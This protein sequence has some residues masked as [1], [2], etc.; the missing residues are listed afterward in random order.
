MISYFAYDS[1]PVY[2]WGSWFAAMM[3]TIVARIFLQKRL[4]TDRSIAL[5]K[6]MKY[7]IALNA[8]IGIVQA[9]SFLFFPSFSFAE[10]MIQT[11]FML[12]LT[13]GSIST[14][15]GYKPLFLAHSIPIIT[16]LTLAWALV[17]NSDVSLIIHVGIAALNLAYFAVQYSNASNHFRLFKQ[18]YEIREQQAPLNAELEEKNAKL[19]AA[20][21]LAV[22]ARQEA[23]QAN[24]SKTRFLASASHDLRQPTHALS[25]LA[26]VLSKRPLDEKSKAIASDI[27]T[28]S[29]GLQSLMSGLLDISKLD[30]GLMEPKIEL[31]D[32]HWLVSRVCSEFETDCEN[33][34]LR[35]ILNSTSRTAT[36]RGDPQLTERILSNL[37][38]NAVK[39]T[40]EGRVEVKLE[41]VNGSWKISIED[42]GCGIRQDEQKRIFEEFY[43]V[44]NDH[45]D[46]SNGL[47]LGLAI[48]KRLSDVLDINL[49]FESEFG[50]GSR[51]WF[52]LPKVNERTD[53]PEDLNQAN[54]LTGLHVLCV[55]D[56]AGIRNAL[57]LVF[58]VL[59]CSFDLVEDTP[60][61]TFAAKHKKPDIVLADF[62]LRGDDNGIKT[63]HAIRDLYPDIP[64]LLVTGD[65][66]P[67]RL[68]HASNVGIEMLH[69]PLTMEKLAQSVGE[70]VAKQ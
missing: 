42:T 50:R 20:L 23:D 40:D 54:V 67:E 27:H 70:A 10:K 3:M 68:K 47:G 7:A 21:S 12:G 53:S 51:F 69:K 14:N 33:K 30:A 32:L 31:V 41:E 8:V 28:A 48:V 64:A 61:A 18:S 56:E 34:G 36:T 46:Q 59:G 13:N 55:D 63:I 62:R 60:S 5:K 17:P 66:S 11:I 26:G 45:R 39:Y 9:S 49:A 38:S 4:A 58:E 16:A 25:L 6:R 43:Q 1:L 2:A 44:D 57:T 22:Q 37:I 65:T 19:D 15:S 35:L 52:T 24:I 29:Q